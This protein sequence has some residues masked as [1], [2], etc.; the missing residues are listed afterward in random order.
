[1]DVMI[2]AKPSLTVT[3]NNYSVSVP[4]GVGDNAGSVVA[5]HSLI[6]TGTLTDS[7][8]DV[9]AKMKTEADK[10]KVDLAKMNTFD[11]KLSNLVG[12]FL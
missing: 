9:W 8:Q 10:W 12:K 5:R 3:G 1:M 2:M 4:V 6:V 11:S 7:P